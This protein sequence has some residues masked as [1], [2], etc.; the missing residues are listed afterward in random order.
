MRMKQSLPIC[1]VRRHALN[2][3][4]GAACG[5]EGQSDRIMIRIISCLLPRI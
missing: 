5:A 1:V 4:C 3:D 2:W